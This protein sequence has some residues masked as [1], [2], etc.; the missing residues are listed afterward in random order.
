MIVSKTTLTPKISITHEG[1]PVQQTDKLN[2]FGPPKKEH[3]NATCGQHYF[4]IQR[5]GHWHRQFNTN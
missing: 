2:Y 5:H 3:H 4:M 1:K